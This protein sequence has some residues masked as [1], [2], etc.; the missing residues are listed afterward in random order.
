MESNINVDNPFFTVPWTM[1][2]ELAHQCG[3]MREDEANFIAYLA[4]KE[5]DDA[6]MRY[7]GLLLAYDNA[8]AALRKADPEAATQIAAGLAPSVQRDLA[9]RAEHWARYE[10]PVQEASNA[11]ND[12]YLKANNQ[13]D[14]MRSYGRMVDLLLAEQRAGEGDPL[15]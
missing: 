3:F 13:S 9:E 2:H 15:S 10:G 11:A 4:C 12:A 6:L 1:A 5:S 7:S 14:G 8:T